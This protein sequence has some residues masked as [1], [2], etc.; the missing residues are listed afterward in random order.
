MGGGFLLWLL[1]LGTLFAD[2][3]QFDSRLIEEESFLS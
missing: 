3:Q 2:L 1:M